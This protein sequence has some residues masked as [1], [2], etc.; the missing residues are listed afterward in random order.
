MLWVMKK[1]YRFIGNLYWKIFGGFALS[2]IWFALGLIML[3]T[4]V[5]FPVAVKCFKVGYFVFKP[6]GKQVVTVFD[7]PIG[8]LLWAV[9]AGAVMGGIAVIGALTAAVG[10]ITAPL[11]VQWIKVAR[12]SVFPFSS[13]MR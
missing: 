12:V 6:F 7:R 3:V 5:G 8:Q 4:V 13:Y 11:S 2:L 9:S 1:V 10:L